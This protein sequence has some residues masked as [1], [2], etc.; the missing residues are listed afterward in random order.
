MKNA[1]K[2]SVVS[3]LA[4]ALS[5]CA[6]SRD[7]L[8]PSLVGSDYQEASVD[9]SSQNAA[10]ADTT[11]PNLG[12]T[13]FEPIAVSKGGNTGTFVGQKVV[14]YRNDLTQL[15]GAIKT[16]N[17]ELQKVRA[18]IIS[19][20]Q[21]YHKATG[22]MEAKLQVGTTPGNPQMYAMLQSAQ[23]N[24]QVMNA[25][26]I[27]LNQLSARVTSDAT[28][29]ANLLASIRSSY[30]ISGAVDEDHRQLRILENETNQTS[31]LINS[32]LSE[33]NLDAARQQ[34]YVETAGSY[35]I[36]LDSAIRQGNYGIGSTIDTSTVIPHTSA[37]VAR[38]SSIA[39]ASIGNGKPLFVAKFNRQ[40]VDYKP[41]LRSAVEGARSRKAN[42]MFDVV[43]VS[44]ASGNQISATNA[45]NNANQ[46]FQEIIAMG[47]GAD[48][49]TISARTNASVTA[50]EVQIFVR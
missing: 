37:T 7:A 35:L 27:A 16:H 17:A 42:V 32:L 20:A 22:A 11:I 48:K 49:V 10:V 12:T 2:L 28:M 23:N 14:S 30:V 41:A 44:P 34:Q 3:M 9:P 47:V 50:P 29:T 39:P 43:A 21:A 5:A 6:F 31:I 1:I 24:I 15:Q 4:L 18:S 26:A 45:R 33:I 25:N 13:S 46:I 36:S 19:N 38:S 8:F 40:D